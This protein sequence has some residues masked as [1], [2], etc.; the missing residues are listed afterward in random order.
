[1][2]GTPTW[3]SRA[4]AMRRVSRK[5]ARGLPRWST[6]ESRESTHSLVSL[7]SMSG[8]ECEYPSMITLPAY[9]LPGQGCAGLSAGPGYARPLMGTKKIAATLIALM[10]AGACGGDSDG[11]KD[12]PVAAAETSTTTAAPESTTTSAPAESSTT[13]TVPATPKTTA[14]PAAASPTTVSTGRTS[15]PAQ[16]VR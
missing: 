3:S 9:G 8:S 11:N 16:T 4:R 10:L 2:A 1:M 12:A 13:T 15:G 5:R 7:G 6:T 14:K